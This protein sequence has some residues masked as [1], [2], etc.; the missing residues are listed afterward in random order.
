MPYKSFLTP[1]LS[2]TETSYLYLFAKLLVWPRL[3]ACSICRRRPNKLLSL[4]IEKVYMEKTH[5]LD[6]MINQAAAF[7]VLYSCM[8]V[9]H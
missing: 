3:R 2:K 1:N 4:R 7:V 5:L 6:V 9:L 8:L